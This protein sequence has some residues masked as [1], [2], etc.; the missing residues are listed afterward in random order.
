LCRHWGQSPSRTS[1]RSPATTVL[2]DPPNRRIRDQRG[3]GLKQRGSALFWSRWPSKGQHRRGLFILAW[4]AK[5]DLLA[6]AFRMGEQRNKLIKNPFSWR[7]HERRVLSISPAQCGERPADQFSGGLGTKWFCRIC[8]DWCQ[9]TG[10][11]FCKVDA[12]D[13]IGHR[14]PA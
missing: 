8:N 2:K 12:N 1:K 9:R 6:P 4:R 5:R 7:G 13:Q 3:C 11:G 10:H 14:R